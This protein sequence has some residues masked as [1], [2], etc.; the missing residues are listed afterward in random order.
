VKVGYVHIACIK[1][2]DKVT[3]FVMENLFLSGCYHFLNIVSLEVHNHHKFMFTFANTA[4]YFQKKTGIQL[5][6][7]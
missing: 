4:L 6:L 5:V 2:T 1:Y 7:S 3:D